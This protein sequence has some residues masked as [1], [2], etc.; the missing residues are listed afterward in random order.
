MFLF[1]KLINVKKTRVSFPTTNLQ[2]PCCIQR[3]LTLINIYYRMRPGSFYSTLESSNAALSV[4]RRQQQTSVIDNMN[5]NNRRR[6]SK[7]LKGA[8][9]VQV[10]DCRGQPPS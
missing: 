8:N 4:V 7:C 5:R 1:R 9:G 10:R 6:L 2:K 3:H